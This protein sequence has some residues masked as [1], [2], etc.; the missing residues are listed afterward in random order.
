LL[1]KLFRQAR[2]PIFWN[3]EPAY[4]HHIATTWSSSTG[5]WEIY[6]DGS[7]VSIMHDVASNITIPAGGQFSLQL[8]GYMHNISQ[9]RLNIWNYEIDGHAL[10]LMANKGPL[11]EN[12][13]IFAWYGIKSRVKEDFYFKETPDDLNNSRAESVYQ[14]SFPE[15]SVK[16]YVKIEKVV[17]YNLTEVSSCFWAKFLKT[18]CAIFGYSSLNYNVE[19]QAFLY[20][21]LVLELEIKNIYSDNGPKISAYDSW[22]FYCLQWRSFDGLIEVYQD[23]K[24]RGTKYRAKN[25]TIHSNGVVVLGQELDSYGGGFQSHQAFKGSLAGLNLWSQF[26]TTNVIQGMASGVLNIN[27]NLLQ[28]R[29][30]RDHVFGNIVIQNETEAGLPEHRVQ[31]LRDEW[32]ERNISKAF[33]YARFIR[34][35][36]TDG[37]RW[38]CVEAAAMLDENMCYD[39]TKNSSLYHTKDTKKELLGI[40]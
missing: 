7:L 1:F 6:L 21:S 18:K 22:H 29:D 14:M 39:I 30:F 34:G 17:N 19:I 31:N 32:C 13:N 9:S 2:I 23:G 4:W 11:F 16:N 5:H 3:E 27:G 20:D 38:R 26:L 33:T 10:S 35:R 36:D 37:Y 40:N 24:K 8:S 15:A 12:G 28:W 25:H